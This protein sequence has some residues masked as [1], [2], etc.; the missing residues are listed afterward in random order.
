[1]DLISAKNN[2]RKENVEAH[3]WQQLLEEGQRKV[4]V[5]DDILL[6]LKSQKYAWA[7]D[8]T[9]ERKNLLTLLQMGLNVVEMGKHEAKIEFV[10]D[11][12]RILT[13]YCCVEEKF[14][15]K[16]NYKSNYVK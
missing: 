14:S 7:N 11:S 9:C 6:P 13:N 3:K 2:C 1:M 12:R 4:A 10:V 15:C 8:K 16:G 5:K